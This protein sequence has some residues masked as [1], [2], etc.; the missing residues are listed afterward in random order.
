M[1]RPCNACTHDCDV[2]PDAAF[3]KWVWLLVVTSL[4]CYLLG[5]S[6]DGINDLVIRSRIVSCGD[7]VPPD[8]T[9]RVERIEVL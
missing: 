1:C 5:N 6:E 9:L 3:G 8:P 4:R 2:G 7:E